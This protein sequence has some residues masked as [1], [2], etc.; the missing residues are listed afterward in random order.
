MEAR[1]ILRAEQVV[2]AMVV[3]LDLTLR[4]SSMAVMSQAAFPKD[5]MSRSARIAPALPSQFWI[6]SEAKVAVLSEGSC[7]A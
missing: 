4:L 5:C 2:L 6:F 1:V 3:L 7:G